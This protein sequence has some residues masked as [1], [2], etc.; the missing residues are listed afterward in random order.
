[1]KTIGSH[2][3]ADNFRLAL[4][5]ILIVLFI[6]IFLHY[7]EKSERAIERQSIQQTRRNIDSALV[8]VFATYAS[9][10]RLNELAALDGANPF[11]FLKEYL[12][13]PLSYRG[14]PE[15]ND[16]AVLESGWY[17]LPGRGDL[18]Y[19]PFH[20]SRPEYFRILLDY[21]DIDQNGRFESGKDQFRALR[22]VKK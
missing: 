13:F 6:Y 22:L 19:I 15:V 21:E 3:G 2:P 17:Y 9:E 12:V 4:M 16:P 11:E 20:L 8:I 5:V 7:A 10:R 18:M 14:E 1:M